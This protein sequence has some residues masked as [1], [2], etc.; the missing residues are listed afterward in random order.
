MADDAPPQWRS[1]RD[2]E[3]SP[4]PPRLLADTAAL[5]R[6]TGEPDVRGAVWRLDPAERDL[7]S[8]VVALPPGGVIEPHLGPDLDVLVHV[9]GGSGS[10]ATEADAVELR[11]GALLW[12]PRRS[13]RGFTAGP[14]GLRYLTVHRRRQALVLE[15][16]APRGDAPGIRGDA[17]GIR[18]D[19]P[20]PRGD[21]PADRPGA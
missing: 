21:A 19:A 10:L 3:P 6:R 17:P 5:A 4:G 16:P 2:P 18:G 11:P 1:G 7:D 8:N 20:A 14:A 9:L 12:L 15:P 13:L